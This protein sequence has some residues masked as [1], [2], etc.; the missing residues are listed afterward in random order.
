MVWAGCLE[1][2]LKV[3][4]KLPRLVLEI[5]LGGGDVFHVRVGGLLVV[6]VFVTVSGNCNPLGAPLWPPPTAFGAPLSTFVGSL[7]RC[8]S[9]TSGDCPSVTL[10]KNVPGCFLSR[11]VS[12]DV[13]KHLFCGLRLITAELV[14]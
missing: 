4:S 9:T 12:S 7:G 6:V 3:I 13:V 1:K 5:T 2:L 10:D 8:P 14:H 11:G